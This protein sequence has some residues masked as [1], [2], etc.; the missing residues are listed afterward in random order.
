[1]PT[2]DRPSGP[3][4][5]T[6]IVAE[7][8]RR[9]LERAR[10]I[11]DRTHRRE[12]QAMVEAAEMTRELESSDIDAM[13]TELA[14]VG[15]AEAIDTAA[16]LRCARALRSCLRGDDAAGHAEWEAVMAEHPR[17]AMPYV[18]RA[19]WW[20]DTKEEPGHALPDLDRA[21]AVEPTDAS[22]YFWRAKCHERLGDVD[23]AL[24]NYR[25]AAAIEPE[26]MDV[27]HALAKALSEHGEPDEAKAAW[28]RLIALAPGYVDFHLGRAQQLE[29]EDDY[30][31]AL[32]D[33]DRIIEL[34]PTAG[35]FALRGR[36]HREAGDAS[37]ALAD[38]D[39][40]LAIDPSGD[41]VAMERLN[42]LVTSFPRERSRDQVLDEVERLAGRMPDQAP[43]AVLHAFVLRARGDHEGALEAWNRAI[44]NDPAP[45]ARSYLERATAHARL[46]HVEEAF[47]DATRAIE[48]DPELVDAFV[49]RGIYRSHLEDDYVAALADLDRAL[50]LS[51]NDLAAHFHRGQ[52]LFNMDEY[53]EAFAA[54]EKAIALAPTLGQLY[55]ERAQCRQNFVADSEVANIA[56]YDRALELGYRAVE[57]FV[58]KS[59][60]QRWRDDIAG[61]V[62]TLD[63][64]AQEHP[65]EGIVF[66][67]RAQHREDLGD[68]EGAKADRARVKELGFEI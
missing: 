39:R 33:Y 36:A 3:D 11:A 58:E 56:D 63:A 12:L 62:A 30:D 7:L 41:V 54:R 32:A 1:M 45:E 60:Q 37:S 55:F 23:R 9:Q 50:E 67:H 28:N 15:D 25:R 57:V 26:S 27:V 59:I 19:R 5:V 13:L 52:M 35:A 46:G 18:M 48:R 40:S 20:L 14:Q 16:R 10:A 21:A 4:K 47:D 65:R 31:G 2:Q 51:P 53:E 22:A 8:E 43:I 6:S 42:L 66:F 44:E 24:A 64:G 38:F 49:A 61:A 17:L 34:D 29:S 68:E